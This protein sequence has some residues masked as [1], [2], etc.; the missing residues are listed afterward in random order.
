MSKK[1]KSESVT[2]AEPKGTKSSVLNVRKVTFGGILAII[3]IAVMLAVSTKSPEAGT[4][5]SMLYLLADNGKKSGRANGN[6]YQKNG[7]VRAWR[8]PAIVRNVYTS[9]V[10]AVLASFSGNWKNLSLPNQN[11][12]R[13]FS[14]PKYDR[15]GMPF[16]VTGKN[17]YVSA[18][19]NISSVGGSAILIAPLGAGVPKATVATTLT[20]VHSSHL[21]L[22][23]ST[24]VDG[25]QTL[26]SATAPLSLGSARPSLS[27]FRNI[28]IQ[29]TSVAGPIDLLADYEHK[30]GTMPAGVKVFVRVK[31]IDISTGLASAESFVDCVTT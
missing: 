4:S 16:N 25:T 5:L 19:A 24:N 8:A 7:R 6:V 22:G 15:F 9:T 14:F 1:I 28:S 29:D 3:A 26:V 21:D 23:Y 10:R 2:D 17:A 30:F 31:V 20:G 12:W 13:S 18:N 11:S 27:K